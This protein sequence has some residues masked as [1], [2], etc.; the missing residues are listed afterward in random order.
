MFIAR[1]KDAPKTNN[2][3][4]TKEYL[5]YM[6]AKRILEDGSYRVADINDSMI[7]LDFPRVVGVYY[8]SS[9]FEILN[10]EMKD[11]SIDQETY[12]LG[13]VLSG[14]I[15][16]TDFTSRYSSSYRECATTAVLIT[17]EV[18]KILNQRKSTKV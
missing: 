13:Q 12:L 10:S 9:W 3:Q 16:K 17:D 14:L 4:V 5:N 7:S 2:N 15:G 1:L 11:A 8:P 6:A 18:M